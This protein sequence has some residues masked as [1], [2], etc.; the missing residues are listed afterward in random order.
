MNVIV[1]EVAGFMPALKGMR[2]PTKTKCDS[3]LDNGKFILGPKDKKLTHSL[4]N[5]KEYL[6]FIT[7]PDEEY[8]EKIFGGDVHGKFQRGIIAWLNIDAPRYIWS[9]LDTYVI[10]MNPISSEST[11]YTLIKESANITADMFSPHTPQR[12]IDA[13]IQ[14]ID[15]LTIIYNTR[16]DIPIEIIKS[17]L[18]EGWMQGRMRAYS[19]QTLRRIHLYRVKH[20]LPEW[21]IICKAIEELPYANELIFGK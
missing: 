16:K 3:Y 20:R 9:E 13:F 11:M 2:F 17:A 15:D 10:G 6:S 1:E 19:Y 21:Q 12:M 8:N 7:A 14:T 5:K 18:P 4:L